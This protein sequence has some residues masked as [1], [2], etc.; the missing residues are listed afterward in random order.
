M[1]KVE[2]FLSI[3]L[4][5]VLF[6]A[7]FIRLGFF[8][9]IPISSLTIPVTILIYVVSVYLYSCYNTQRNLRYGLIGFV[10]F[11]L[12]LSLLV[13]PV[14]RTYD[15]S[16]DGQSYHQS[17]MIALATGWNPAYESTLNLVQKLPNE[18]FVQG[19]PSVLW[20]I[21][22]SVYAITGK[23]NAGKV[24]NLGLGILALF[25]IY[26]LLRRFGISRLLGLFIS[27]LVVLQP[28]FVNQSM[29]YM[30]DGAGYCLF[31]ITFSL[32]IIGIKESKARWSIFLFFLCCLLLVSTKYNNLIFVA[33]FV[34]SYG[35]IL[36]NRL[37]N[38]EYQLRISNRFFLSLMFTGVV[39]IYLPYI[40]N[41]I[42]YQA[43]FFP[44]N[45]KEYMGAVK[46]N[47]IPNNINE[48]DKLKLL[49]FGIFS[50]SQNLN[51]GNPDSKDN[52]AILKIPFTFQRDEIVASVH[53]YNNRV[54]A[55]GPL[56]SG[57]IVI[58]LLVLLW[59]FYKARHTDQVYAVHTV[60]F[61]TSIF[62]FLALLTP[63]PNLL[64]YVPQ[65]QLIPFVIFIG[66]YAYFRN[67]LLRLSLYAL[68]LLI[69]SNS[70]V[71]TYYSYIKTMDEKRALDSHY[72]IMKKSE[73]KYHVKA[74][75]FYSSY[76]LLAEKG[77]PFVIVDT[78]TCNP[79]SQLPETATTTQYCRK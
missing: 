32:M 36:F 75:H 33:G 53:L 68:L 55:G 79:I 45:I 72:N 74:Q 40:R 26:I 39:I 10:S 70:A 4:T 6:L 13:Y 52:V 5:Y 25:S 42:Y 47:N 22:S 19:Y 73:R 38:G 61:I 31:L 29:T 15:T 12:L 28:V 17:A 46:Y 64:R 9:A 8:L 7:C 48:N 11:I 37:L 54:G 34:I 27:A 60:L 51:S 71:Y 66:L 67:K 44:T 14:S 18:V 23:I 41:A 50:S 65:L 20:E 58:S 30:Q 43:P 49:F 57:I 3:T 16:W 21:Q 1:S 24:V 63:S 78:L 69:A 59:A 76:H 77:V 2:A 62:I 56:F 35:F